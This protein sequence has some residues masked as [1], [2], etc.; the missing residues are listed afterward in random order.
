M[1]EEDTA[2]IAAITCALSCNNCETVLL[3]DEAHLLRAVTH[4]ARRHDTIQVVEDALEWSDDVRRDNLAT[5][6][7]KDSVLVPKDNNIANISRGN[8]QEATLITQECD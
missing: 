4:F 7:S 6:P 5:A 2:S 3:E 8:G 1:S